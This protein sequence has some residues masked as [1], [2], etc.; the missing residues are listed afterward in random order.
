MYER[1]LKFVDS[2]GCVFQ[3]GIGRSPKRA[4]ERMQPIIIMGTMLGYLH[5]CVLAYVLGHFS[6]LQKSW[7][8]LILLV[9]LSLISFKFCKHDKA[10]YR[11]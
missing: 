1:E 5:K 10:S 2:H 11:C 4:I 6:R 3:D 8:Q 7:T 9:R